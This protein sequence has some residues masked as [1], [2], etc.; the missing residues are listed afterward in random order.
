ML[1]RG[2]LFYFNKT[3]LFVLVLSSACCAQCKTGQ[4]ED[5]TAD[6]ISIMTP[7]PQKIV[8]DTLESSTMNAD[9]TMI[10][11]VVKVFHKSDPAANLNYTVYKK[12][13]D[14]VV[15]KGEFRGSDVLWNDAQSIKLIPY[16]GMEKKPS[17][18]NPLEVS[19][20]GNANR[21]KVIKLSDSLF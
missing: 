8:G 14:S 13:T 10:L 11:R 12:G 3:L 4:K 16:V 21:P 5:K 1:S 2:H 7:L 17:S 19:N 20:T 18:E 15:K 6:N 9:K